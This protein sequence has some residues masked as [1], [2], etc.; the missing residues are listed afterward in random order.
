MYKNVIIE[1]INRNSN[2]FEQNLYASFHIDEILHESQTK[3]ELLKSSIR[4]FDCVIDVIGSEIN[5]TKPVLIIPLNPSEVIRTDFNITDLSGKDLGEESP[6]IYLIKRD[7]DKYFEQWEEYLLPLKWNPFQRHKN[8]YNIYYRTYRD[9]LSFQND[10]EYS[11]SI[12]IE[13]YPESLIL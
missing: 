10:W 6:S 11:R 7:L 4:L 13:Y 5:N 3:E 12:F 1:W 8:R 2:N 9:P